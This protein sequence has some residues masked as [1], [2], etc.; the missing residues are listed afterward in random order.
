ML[1][2]SMLPLDCVFNVG[3]WLKFI[4]SQY[5]QARGLI[6][7]AHRMEGLGEDKWKDRSVITTRYLGRRRGKSFR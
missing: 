5:N 4:R 7:L 1:K 2:M 3:L 6:L